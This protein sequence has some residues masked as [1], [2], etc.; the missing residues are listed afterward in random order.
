LEDDL[1]TGKASAYRVLHNLYVLIINLLRD[2]NVENMAAE[3]D[4]FADKFTAI[5]Q[6]LTQQ[7]VL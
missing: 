4:A 7:M 6:F 2:K 1:R 3:I 5:I